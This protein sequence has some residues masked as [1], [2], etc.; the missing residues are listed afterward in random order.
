M[1]PFR[2]PGRWRPVVAAAGAVALAVLGSGCGRFV[3]IAPVGRVSLPP[4]AETSV[5]VDAAG[6]VLAELHAEQDRDLV[7]LDRVPRVLREAVIAVE[8]QR[9]YEHAGVDARAIARAVKENTEAGRVTQGG[10]TITQQLAKNAVTGDEQTLERKLTEASLA[11]QLERE[12]TKDEILEQ[13][14]NTVYF[15]NGAYGVQTAARRYFGVDVSQLTLPQ[16]ALLAGLLKAPATYDPRT[17]PEA[18]RARRDL[19]LSLMASQRRIP[20]EEARAARAEPVEVLPPRSSERHRAP[21]FVAHVLERLQHDDAFAVLGP[22]PVSRA[23]RI[24]RGGLRVETTLDPHWQRSAEEAVLGG[25]DGSGGLRAALVALDP[26]TGAIRAMV[27]GRD[28]YDPED[29]AARFNLATKARRQPGST[30]KELVLAAAIAQGH[31]L[32]E[33]FPAP[34]TVTIPPAPPEEPT[35]WEVGNYEGRDF[36]ELTLRDATAFSVNVVYAQL[37]EQVGPATVADLAE[38][39]GIRRDLPALR[40]LALGAVEVTPLELATVQAT[41][42]T[43]GIYHAPSD[44]VRIVDADGE[45]LWERPEPTG[46]RVI[47]EAVAW[48]TTTAL[49]DVVAYGTGERANINRPMAGKTGTTQEGADA[50]FAGYTPDM[51]AAVWI[52]FPEGRV[53]MVPPRTPYPVEGGNL[54]AET[55]ARFG[56]QALADVPAAQFPIPEVALTRVRVDTT[57]HC[58]PNPYTPPEVVAERAYLTGTE[59]TEICT[60]PTGPPTTDVPDVTG[61][62]AEVAERTLSNAGFVVEL[63][64]EFS[65]VLPPGYVVRQDPAP[66][67]GLTLERGY[68]VTLHTS[69]ADRRPVPVPD[70]LNLPLDEARAALE[71]AGFVVEVRLGCPDG[72]ASCTGASQRPGTVWEQSPDTGG[73]APRASVVQL[74][75]YPA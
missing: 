52:G 32:D 72:A 37:M 54:P 45:V 71:A 15:G 59:P 8:D 21:W 22:D 28:Y 36:G 51:A 18:A 43:G 11:L 67:S 75:A 19:V 57:R 58:L 56:V 41:L 23:E 38:A 31:S 20:A 39:A 35:P 17:A 44:V 60:E 62:P 13:Y 69:V 49:A 1:H 50:W 10:S 24:F 40:S 48:L 33:V 64:E 29:P 26:A 27:G 68:V 42:A 25:V 7:P 16:A 34:A 61:L 9:F 47:D 14:L 70:V 65:V 4:P 30:F 2:R 6:A 55:F 3:D 73:T 63:R 53:P 66:G 5:V 74:S 12:F 46:E